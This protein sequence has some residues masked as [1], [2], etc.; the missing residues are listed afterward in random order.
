MQNFI[1]ITHEPLFMS[2][3]GHGETKKAQL[4]NNTALATTDSND[5]MNIPHRVHKNMINESKEQ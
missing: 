2:Y 4:K 1:E 3:P 5:N